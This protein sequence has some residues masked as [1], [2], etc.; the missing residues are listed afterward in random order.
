MVFVRS[1]DSI[2]LR[3][4][5]SHSIVFSE[6]LVDFEIPLDA[7]FFLMRGRVVN[8]LNQMP[9]CSRFAIGLRDW[10][11]FRQIGPIFALLV[12]QARPYTTL[13]S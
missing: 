4:L 12:E 13:E 10:A 1:V 3:S 7:E 6:S 8:V 5:L 11:G 2:P 9:E